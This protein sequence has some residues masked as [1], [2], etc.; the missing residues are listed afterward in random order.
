M[1]DV[2]RTEFTLPDDAAHPT[3]LQRNENI[4]AEAHN[5]EA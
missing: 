5:S 1:S 3:P 2:E 4:E